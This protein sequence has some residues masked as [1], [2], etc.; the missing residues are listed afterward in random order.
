MAGSDRSHPYDALRQVR[1]LAPRRAPSP[2][3]PGLLAGLLLGGCAA[4]RCEGSASPAPSPPSPPS[5]AVE[6]APGASAGTAPRPVEGLVLTLYFANPRYV[7]TGDEALP[8][9]V[10]EAR[11]APPTPARAAAAL[12]ELLEVGPRAG[13]VAVAP[14]GVRARVAG[15]TAGVVTVDFD[16]EG[17]AGGSL[18][19]TMLLSA[20]VWTLTE[21]PGV[22]AVRFTVAG[23]TAESLM[24]HV[25]TTQPL[26]RAD[27]G[28]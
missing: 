17:L 5:A 14:P 16:R 28:R 21:L 26:R 12:R 1:R 19:E 7:A 3:W 13:G 4:T 18:A 2:L 8:P 22:D 15:V 10:S 6:P 23:A 27:L 9:L 25:D 11:S 24:G 20:I